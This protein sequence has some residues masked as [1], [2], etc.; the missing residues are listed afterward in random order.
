MKKQL[1]LGVLLVSL[2]ILSC[3]SPKKHTPPQ[4]A[5]AS[6]ERVSVILDT[7]MGP[8]VDDAGALAVLHAFA[9]EG[10]ARLLGVMSSNP[11]QWAAPT[12]DVINTY[13]GRGD[14]PIGAPRTGGVIIANTYEWNEQLV[15]RYPHNL[16]STQNATDA[17]ATYRKILGNEP[18]SSVTIV[19]IGFLTNLRHL[20]NAVPDSWSALTGKQLVARKVKRLVVMGGKFPQ[21]KEFNLE[22]DPEAAMA[23]TDNWPTPILFSGFEIGERVLTG[24]ELIKDS[25]LANSPVRFAF[26][27]F[28]EKDKA[29]NRPS[30]D[31]TAVWIA[32]RGLSDHFEAVPGR[33]RV[34][35]DGHNE[36]V[37]TP[38]GTHQYIRFKTSPEKIRADVEELMRHAPK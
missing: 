28:L 19:T 1:Q 25:T 18:D 23:V 21:G 22:L 9:D 36:W 32:V 8:D 2:F 12:I 16:D 20:L 10:E 13:F 24:Q 34:Y 14:L 3:E 17:V 38:S 35:N 26:Q 11:N 6:V 5:V 31:Q 27:H 33:C 37:S 29:P 4:E 7:D 15:P 30:W